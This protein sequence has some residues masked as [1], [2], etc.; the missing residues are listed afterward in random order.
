MTLSA[1]VLST[2]DRYVAT[3]PLWS[4]PAG[5]E[6]EDRARRWTIGLAEQIRYEHG[7]SYGNKR[8]D[9][10]RP[11]SKDAIAYVPGI[12][13]WQ[14][15]EKLYAYDMLSGAG[16]GSPTLV[17]NPEGQDITGQV[18]VVAQPVDHLSGVPTPTP[19]PPPVIPYDEGKSIEFGTACN[20][21]YREAHANQDP[22]MISVHSQR[23]AW[24]YY[25]GGLEW[26]VSK[27][28]HINELRAVYGLAPI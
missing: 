11:I 5:P 8:A 2:R 10:G 20:D 4:M 25:V 17:P 16:T 13:P 22:G 24:D 23:A 28:K 12:L 26:P 21:V 3:F 6:A 9:P 1:A 14:P 19:E 18:F 7:P 27:R 15:Y